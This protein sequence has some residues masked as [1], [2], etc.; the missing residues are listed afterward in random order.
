MRALDVRRVEIGS[1]EYAQMLDL[2]NRVLRHPLGLELT[3][4]DLEHDEHA[5]L[6]VALMDG[7]VVG[8][9]LL[10]REE[11]RVVQ[12]RAMAVEPGLQGQGVGRAVVEYAEA[13]A[14]ELDAREIQ[15]DSRRTALGFYARLGFVAEGA[16]Y[17]KVGIPHRLMRKRLS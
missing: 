15:L 2:R 1:A 4:H 5:D 16:E 11:G 12:L 10:T 14:R 3:P 13:R 6:L 9:C 8:C 17:E 7:R